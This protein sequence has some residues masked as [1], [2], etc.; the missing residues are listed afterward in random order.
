MYALIMRACS[1]E[2]AER[3]VLEL[4]RKHASLSEQTE[5]KKRQERDKE[6]ARRKERIARKKREEEEARKKAMAQNEDNVVEMSADGA[7]DTTMPTVPT[8]S[9]NTIAPAVP[10][11]SIEGD[12]NADVKA[13]NSEAR[14][15]E[16]SQKIEEQEEVHSFSAHMCTS[17][18]M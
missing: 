7:F 10:E 5:T 9:P 13:E 6:E 16:D 17:G 8:P 4:V 3:M 15:E 1:K 12:A 2:Q 18:Q 11:V 14:T